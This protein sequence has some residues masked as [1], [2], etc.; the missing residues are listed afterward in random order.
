MKKQII[1]IYSLIVLVI[2]MACRDNAIKTKEIISTVKSDKKVYILGT[3]NDTALTGFALSTYKTLFGDPFKRATMVDTTFELSFPQKQPQIFTFINLGGTFF[4]QYVYITPGDS[5]FV[6]L[7]DGNPNFEGKNAAHYNFNFRFAE[8]GLEWPIYDNDIVLH[9]KNTQKVYDKKLHFFKEYVKSNPEVTQGFKNFTKSELKFEYLHNLITP[10][11]GEK[12]YHSQEPIFEIASKELEKLGSTFNATEYFDGLVLEDY[13]HQEF[14]NN[15]FFKSTLIRFIRYYF[16]NTTAPMYSKERF[17]LEKKFIEDNFDADIKQFAISR[18]NYDYYKKVFPDNMDNIENIKTTLSDY[19]PVLK[20][21]Y[22][23]EEMERVELNLTNFYT[24]IPE[25]VRLEEIVAF[26]NEKY[27][28]NKILD[29]ERETVKI[30]DFWASWC[31][32]CIEEIKKGNNFRKKMEA[33][34]NV[35]WIYI[36]IDR[37]KEDWLNRSE[38]LAEYGLTKNQFLLN[39]AKNSEFTK[40]FDLRDIPKY[41]ILDKNGKLV[42]NNAPRPSDTIVFKKIIKKVHLD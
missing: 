41:A 17:N 4:M 24:D 33:E 13:Q 3:T 19:I 7:N 20:N 12:G 29:K 14:V 40:F 23:K 18:L 30:I 2:F 8:L 26:N 16:M 6:K 15:Y 25:T 37:K 35:E 22:Y 39:D 27:T 21:P 9:K 28:L 11:V 32:P 36:S 1:Q 10:R 42:L 38:E 34:F 5:I 31:V